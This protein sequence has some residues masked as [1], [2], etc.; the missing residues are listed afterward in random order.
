M[1]HQLEFILHTCLQNYEN[2]QTLSM[3][4]EMRKKCPGLLILSEYYELKRSNV[5][6]KIEKLSFL[7]ITNIS[8]DLLVT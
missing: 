2:E 4:T 8:I 1:G 5:I 6:Q 7:M 3:I